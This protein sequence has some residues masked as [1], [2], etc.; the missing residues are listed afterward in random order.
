[1]NNPKPGDEIH[2]ADLYAEEISKLARQ[3]AQVIVLPEKIVNIT[4]AV[5][6]P[7][8]SIIANAATNN[9]VIIV[10]G[11]TEF[12][13]DSIKQNMALVVS[14]GNLLADYQKVNLFEGEAM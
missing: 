4:A 1:T 5:G 6:F 9:H 12:T 3:G 13:N 8:K 10:A 14:K 7:V 11:Y 2:V